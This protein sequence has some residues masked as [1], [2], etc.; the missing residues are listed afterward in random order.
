MSFLKILKFLDLFCT[1]WCWASCAVALVSS[2]SVLLCANVPG[3]CGAHSE[4]CCGVK[5]S[6]WGHSSSCSA[7]KLLLWTLSFQPNNIRLCLFWFCGAMLGMSN[8]IFRVHIVKPC[9]C[10]PL[11]VG[12]TILHFMFGALFSL[13]FSQISRLVSFFTKCCIDQL[14]LI[15][16]FL[17]VLDSNFVI[18]YL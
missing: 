16:L 12:I 3:H 2:F 18:V 14:I 17:F 9:Q 6:H 15:V 8:P 13:L 10:L 4:Q 11:F 5:W 7:T 1:F